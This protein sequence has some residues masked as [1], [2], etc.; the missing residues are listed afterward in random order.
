MFQKRCKVDEKEEL[1]RSRATSF[2]TRATYRDFCASRGE[3]YCENTGGGVDLR[4]EGRRDVMSRLG[5][6]ISCGVLFW[7]SIRLFPT[8]TCLDTSC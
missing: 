3:L 1:F 4:F 7:G 6:T 2:R 8:E 5:I